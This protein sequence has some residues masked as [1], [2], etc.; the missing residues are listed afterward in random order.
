MDHRRTFLLTSMHVS[1]LLQYF[2]TK[3][4]F[5]DLRSCSID[6]STLVSKLRYDEM[7][8]HFFYIVQN[9]IGMIILTNL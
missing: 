8:R 7:L 3:M 4:G 2:E 1:K 5:I 6:E 9:H